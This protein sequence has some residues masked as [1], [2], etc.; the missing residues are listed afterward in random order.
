[1]SL[2][3]KQIED[4]KRELK[5]NFDKAGI[6]ISKI[7]DDLETTTDYISKLMQLE[8]DRYED[9]WILKNYLIEKV[10]EKGLTETTF[11]ALGG[12]YKKIWFLNA[13]YIDEKRIGKER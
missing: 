2:S 9:T 10:K 12:D 5:E 6:D 4:T 3:A 13:K 7:A 8:P 1:M 11:T